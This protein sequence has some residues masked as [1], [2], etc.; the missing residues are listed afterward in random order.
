[1]SFT[2]VA[3]Y[4]LYFYQVSLF[5]PFC[6][7][8]AFPYYYFLFFF[9]LYHGVF[10]IIAT[11]YIIDILLI[12]YPLFNLTFLIYHYTLSSPSLFIQ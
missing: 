6:I 11:L 10:D 3:L 9:F 12:T 5:D 4:L 2:S 7:I 1:M 8:L